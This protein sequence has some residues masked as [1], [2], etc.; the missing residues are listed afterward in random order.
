M[1]GRKEPAACWFPETQDP[2]SEVNLPMRHVILMICC[3]VLAAPLM[4]ARRAVAQCAPGVGTCVPS[5][6][7]GPH[8]QQEH[9]E[10]FYY[11]GPVRPPDPWLALRSEPS[12]SS[13]HRILEMPEGTLF[14]RLGASGP[15][16]RVQLLDGTVGWA[17]A[18]WIRCCRSH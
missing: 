8:G 12:S 4:P 10:E 17:R 1:K 3:A 9:P 2:V 13:G 7:D 5:S 16:Y 18:D 15:W 14:R 11:V 6:E